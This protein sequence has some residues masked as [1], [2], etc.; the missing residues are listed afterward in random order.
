MLSHFLITIDKSSTHTD[1]N[2][3]SNFVTSQNPHL[4]S[5]FLG[6]WNSISNLI[7]ES[8]LNSTWTDQ[9]KVALDLFVSSSEGFLSSLS[10][11]HCCL[12]S[13]IPFFIF[14]LFNSLLGQ[15]EGTKTILSEIFNKFS[16]IVNYLFLI[17]WIG[18]SIDNDIIGTFAVQ[19]NFLSI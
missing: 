6:E 8:I 19:Y 15:V 14:I 13:F 17:L 7:L 11:N 3:C 9:F 4:D 5:C 10:S 18:Q 2:G 16:S 1:V 12:K